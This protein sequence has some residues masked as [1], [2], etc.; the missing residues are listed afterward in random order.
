M[1]SDIEAH[2]EGIKVI[3]WDGERAYCLDFVS[4][5]VGF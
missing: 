2:L 5:A 4:T 3:E 1:G